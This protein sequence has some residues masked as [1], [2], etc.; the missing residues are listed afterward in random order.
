MARTDWNLHARSRV[1]RACGA[2]FADGDCVRTGVLPFS[3]PLVS[4]LFAE[5]LA[6][7]AAAAIKFLASTEAGFI[8]GTILSVDGGLT[9]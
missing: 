9:A 7:E 8:T 4:E 6:E 2:A 3:D 1:C 5:K